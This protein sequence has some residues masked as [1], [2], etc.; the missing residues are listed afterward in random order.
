MWRSQHAGI[1]WQDSPRRA[2]LRWRRPRT[3]C[4][5]G[6]WSVGVVSESVSAWVDAEGVGEGVVE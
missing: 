3:W 5:A 4:R 6:G 1:G 2:R